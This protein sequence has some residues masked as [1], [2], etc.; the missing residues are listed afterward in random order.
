MKK[1]LNITVIMDSGA[2]PPDLPLQ[3]EF[4]EERGQ[5]RLMQRKKASHS[6]QMAG[7]GRGD[8]RRARS[9]ASRTSRGAMPYSRWK[10]R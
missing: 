9:A 8:Q 7:A 6:A 1:H 2:I 4:A 3:L 10:A 5:R